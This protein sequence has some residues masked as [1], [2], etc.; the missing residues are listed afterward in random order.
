MIAIVAMIVTLLAAFS[1]A[2]PFIG[3]ALGGAAV[4][5][6]VRYRRWQQ[7]GVPITFS[8]LLSLAGLFLMA[9]ILP[10]FGSIFFIW[11]QELAPSSEA[12]RKEAEIGKLLAETERSDR[13]VVA[14]DVATKSKSVKARERAERAVL[15]HFRGL[16]A[17]NE[18]ISA[19][20][21]AAIEALLQSKFPTPAGARSCSVFYA[22][23]Y[24]LKDQPSDV[25]RALQEYRNQSD[26]GGRAEYLEKVRRRCA[27]GGKWHSICATQLPKAELA[28][29]KDDPR[30]RYGI[31][32]LL[33]PN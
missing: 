17:R 27:T 4:L 16:D 15:D 26:C 8:K 9:I 18:N 10:W 29:L 6:F 3:I 12:M 31:P 20:D 7:D 14:I 32:P 33:N 13:F 25:F 1:V 5:A 23:L 30:F 24:V 21:L 22:Q 11:N 28:T 2:L 19:P